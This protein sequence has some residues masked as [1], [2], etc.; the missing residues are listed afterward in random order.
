MHT[1]Y[2]IVPIRRRGPIG[3][4]YTMPKI[5]TARVDNDAYERMR[6]RRFSVETLFSGDVDK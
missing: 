4:S 6:G 1:I 3:I 5:R 2:Y